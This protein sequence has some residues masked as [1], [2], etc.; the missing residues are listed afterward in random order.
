MTMLASPPFFVLPFQGVEHNLPNIVIVRSFFGRPCARAALI[1]TTVVVTGYSSMHSSLLLYLP[2]AHVL[3][4]VQDYE[5]HSLLELL[6]RRWRNKWNC[7]TSGILPCLYLFHLLLLSSLFI[8]NILVINHILSHLTI[9][10]C[11][12]LDHNHL[13]PSTTSSIQKGK[14]NFIHTLHRSLLPFS[15]PPS[16]AHV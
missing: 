13:M 11:S 16:L 6:S 3:L 1:T 12:L 8:H 15:L 4:E 7:M 9:Y 14:W 10:I 5:H 2:A